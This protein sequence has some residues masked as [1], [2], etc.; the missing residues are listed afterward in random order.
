MVLSGKVQYVLCCLVKP[1]IRGPSERMFI[2]RVLL[3]AFKC[4]AATQPCAVRAESGSCA[5]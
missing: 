5:C 2:N 1:A 3:D 4:I